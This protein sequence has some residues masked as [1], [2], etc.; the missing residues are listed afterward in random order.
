VSL[1]FGLMVFWQVVG[2]KC[3]SLIYRGI[4]IVQLLLFFGIHNSHNTFAVKLKEKGE[5]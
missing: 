2:V 4:V 1:A 3:R 5:E